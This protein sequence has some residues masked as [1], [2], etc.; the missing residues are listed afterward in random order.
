LREGVLFDG[1]QHELEVGL[2]T[3]DLLSVVQHCTGLR[4][5][6]LAAEEESLW[7]SDEE[8]STVAAI[9]SLTR[10]QH[11]TRL[12]FTPGNSRD[13]LAL[14]QACRVLEGHSLRELHITESTLAEVELAAW[15]QL[16]QLQWLHK[17]LV[18]L[19]DSDLSDSLAKDAEIFLSSLSGCRSVHLCLP[20]STEPF[21]TALAA[22]EEAGMPAPTVVLCERLS[23]DDVHAYGC[24]C[25]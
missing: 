15:L 16:G 14:V 23:N 21:S 18:Q 9:Q 17:L 8:P 7:A 10:L 2:S 19:V 4:D 25:L 13:H 3:S 6:L 20:G 22:L 1:T 24:R 5:L 11:L 12:V